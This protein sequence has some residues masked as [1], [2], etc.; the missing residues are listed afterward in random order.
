M[1]EIHL[2]ET[3]LACADAAAHAR[4]AEHLRWCA[5]CRNTAAEYRWL[6]ER[7]EDT[8]T[9]AADGVVVPRPMWRAVQRQM[10]V[11]QRRRVAGWRA[12]TTAGVTLAICAILS[13]SSLVG[14]TVVAQ[15][16][17]PEAVMT[18]ASLTATVFSGQATSS[19]TPTSPATD[20]GTLLSSVPAL[21]PLSTPP[22]P[23]A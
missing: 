16:S 23:D 1:S 15:T 22:D 2:Q 20:Q 10:A 14:V 4:V 6:G 19:A 3:E 11:D 9:V 12:S 17:L 5:Q 7:I 18:P 8:L 21:V 13:L